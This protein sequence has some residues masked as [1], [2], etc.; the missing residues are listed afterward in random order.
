MEKDLHR[1]Q[2][3]QPAPVEPVEQ[4]KSNK[5]RITFDEYK[6]FAYMITATMKD[7]GR[8]DNV[9]SIKQSELVNRVVQEITLKEGNID[10]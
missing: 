9:E 7:M 1:S 3:N 6:R 2:Q 8:E 5:V 4:P 10:G